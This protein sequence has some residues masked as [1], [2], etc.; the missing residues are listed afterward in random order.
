MLIAIGPIDAAM[1]EPM[2][3][4][5]GVVGMIIAAARIRIAVHDGRPS[6]GASNSGRVV[7]VEDGDQCRIEQQHPHAGAALGMRRQCAKRRNEKYR[8]GDGG[9][10]HLERDCRPGWLDADRRQDQVSIVR[11][12]VH[13][14]A[15]TPLNRTMRRACSEK[16]VGRQRGAAAADGGGVSF[17]T[18]TG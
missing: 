13:M 10:D 16:N 8:D 6:R 5:R 1:R 14:N 18:T 12:N 4:R 2:S 11:P 17:G 9:G 7:Q 3:V 15:L